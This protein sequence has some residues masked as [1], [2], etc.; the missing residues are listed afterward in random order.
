MISNFIRKIK[1]YNKNSEPKE[2]P[3][4]F[5][6]SK[7]KY[8]YL[9]Q[10]PMEAAVFDLKGNY[11]YY[12]E[13][14]IIKSLSQNDII[15]NNDFYYFKQAGIAAECAQKRSDLFN[16]VIEEQKEV[17]FTEK[18]I[19]T[20]TNK[21][22]YY[23][24]YFQPIFVDNKMTEVH[25]YGNDLTAVILAQNELKY[26]AYHDKLTGLKN[27]DSFN[28]QVDQLL[29]EINGGN[30]HFSAILFIDLDNFKIVND[31]FGHDIGDGVLRKVASRLKNL[32]DK[33]DFIYRLGSD[34]FAIIMRK[35]KSE[36]EVGRNAENIIKM[37][38]APYYIQNIKI[39]YFSCSIGIAVIPKDGTKRDILCK[40]ADSALHN[41]KKR[42][43]NT[44]Q[45]YSK[46]ITESSV[47]KLR[48]E[49]N[50]RTIVN[51]DDFENHF[52]VL[53]QPIVEKTSNTEYK[54]IG[55]EALLRW[56][57]TD[58]G[59]IKPEYFIPI[60]EDSDLIS[61]IGDWVLFK[62]ASDFYN[63]QKNWKDP[64]RISVNYSAKQLRSANAIDKVQTIIDAVGIDPHKVQLELT[65]TNY[66]DEHP[67]IS[68]NIAALGE[69]G[70]RLAIDDFG[71]GFAS[72]SYLH[73][74]PASTIKIDKSFIKYFSTRKEHRELVKSIIV[75]GENL[76][77][78]VIA[79]GIEQVEDLYLLATQNCYKYQGFLFSKPL[80]LNDFI[81]YLSK[82]NHLT[83]IIR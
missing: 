9:D 69:M 15:G 42:G 65:E 58:L 55:A 60:A 34:D 26:L 67:G 27:R 41:A 49:N 51:A 1:V 14:Y 30:G 2:S 73:K 68:N 24:R 37:V 77:K 50:L 83:T 25:L 21:T 72:L 82:E 48:I 54:V 79:E 33:S 66:L 23:K 5:S 31:N 12:N 47:K 53:Y 32:F 38:S 76:D 22:R 17:R 71:V 18:L 20:Q 44:F 81:S 11:K 56:N 6:S 59:I 63:L 29:S 75:L 3:Y 35:A 74:V 70:I 52:E 43:N 36:L 78:E 46:S 7:S 39:P 62:A 10:L 16:Q 64:L 19:N 40:H 13:K 4:I 80:N 61:N 45:F 8:S 28:E 57:N